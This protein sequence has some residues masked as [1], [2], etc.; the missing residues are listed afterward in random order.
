[1]N[2]LSWYNFSEIIYTEIKYTVNYSLSDYFIFAY[3]IIF[4]LKS[5]IYLPFYLDPF[6]L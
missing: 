2:I 4:W 3:K 1:M 5:W 6:E